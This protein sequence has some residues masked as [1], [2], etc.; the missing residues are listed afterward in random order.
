MLFFMVTCLKRYTWLNPLVFHIPNILMLCTNY[1]KQYTAS[2]KLHVLGTL[3]WA[4][5]SLKL[6]SR[7]QSQIVLFSCLNLISFNSLPWCMSM[8]LSLQV[9][10]RWLW[11]NSYRSSQL[12]SLSNILASWVSF[13]ELKSRILLSVWRFLSKNTS[14][15]SCIAPICILPSR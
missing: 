2:S 1:E 13:W 12:N 5:F 7:A 6:D 9:R 8:T 10:L 3:D 15:T 4:T 11:R 14:Q